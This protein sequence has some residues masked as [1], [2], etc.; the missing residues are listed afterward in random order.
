MLSFVLYFVFVY[1]EI[2]LHIVL[3][4]MLFCVI[5]FVILKLIHRKTVISKEDY[6][7]TLND[8]IAFYNVTNL[9]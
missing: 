6:L 9:N 5:T 1:K 3:P 2:T 4:L 8:I 7:N